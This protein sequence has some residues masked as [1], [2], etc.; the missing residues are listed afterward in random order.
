MDWTP[1]PGPEP[2]PVAPAEPEAAT[3]ADPPRPRLARRLLVASLTFVVVAGLTAGGVTAFRFFRGAGDQLLSLAP[4]DTF[5]YATVYL[6]PPGS[7]KLAVNSLL[8]R[9]PNAASPSQLD[10]SVNRVLDQA[11]ASSGLTHNDIRPWLGGQVSV[12]VSSAPA[13]STS[14]VPQVAA[15]VSSS[16]DG[17]ARAALKKFEASS[18]GQQFAWSTQTHDGVSLDVGQ[19]KETGELTVFAIV[20][21]TFVFASS[22]TYANEIIDTAHGSHASLSS[23]SDYSTALSQVPTDKLALFYVDVPRLS[24]L[25]SSASNGAASVPFGHFPSSLLQLSGYH[26]LAFALSAQ[27]DGLAFDGVADYDRSKLS[28]GSRAAADLAPSVNSALRFV[29]D[30]AFGL[31]A[32]NGLPQVVRSVLDSFK[33]LGVGSAGID[34][35]VNRYLG[36]LTGDA[37][38]EVDRLPGQ[39][40]P[41]GA[42]IVATDSDAS[43]HQLLDN[44]LHTIGCAAGLCGPSSSATQTYRGTD[45]T[46]LTLSPALTSQ[47]VAPSWAVSGH[48]AIVAS[49]PQEMRSVLDAAAGTNVTTSPRFAGVIHEAD[50]ANNAMLYLDLASIETAVRAIL[51]DQARSVYDS[52]VAQYLDHFTTLVLTTSNSGDRSTMRSFLR[53]Q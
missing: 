11:F 22:A 50:I 51:P 38:L 27:A 15:L 43:A 14:H 45:I 3:P 2:P 20:N 12:V 28:P 17:K 4:D 23:T 40:V 18:E 32:V 21:G 44:A 42:L 34:Q 26:G 6:D 29:P 16:D 35:T 9:F 10:A 30:H 53:V 52:Q 37:A 39:T 36:H 49:N 5:A 47:G 19:R 46:T 31:Y 13:S 25:L 48:M 33:S 8:S 7:Q 24:R 1:A 41:A